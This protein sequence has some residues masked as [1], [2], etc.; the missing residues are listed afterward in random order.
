MKV[1]LLGDA[2]NYHHTLAQ[3][4]RKLG[5][6]VTVAS[7][8]SGWMQTGRDIDISRGSGRMAG[9][10][11]YAK[12]VGP[13]GPKLKGFDV[14]QL[15]S[16]NFV[17]LRPSRLAS[18]FKHLKKNNGAVYLTALGTDSLVVRD[19]LSD[20]PSLAYSEWHGTKGLRPWASTPE[21]H[22]DAWLAKELA[23]YT[24][25]VYEGAD[26]IVTALY[27]Y[28]KIARNNF[29][30]AR[31]AYGGI[32]IDLDAIPEGPERDFSQKIPL[33]IAAHKGRE[34]EKGSNVLLRLLQMVEA[35]SGRIELVRPKKNVP[36]NDFVEL[37]RGCGMV[38]DQLYSYTPATT[39][40]LA[41]A[42]GAIPLSGADEEFYKF[43]GEDT[44]R[45]IFNVDSDDNRQLFIRLME[46]LKK[47]DELARMS[48]EGREF[49]RRHNDATVVAHRFTD[50]WLSK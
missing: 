10:V 47:P 33:L 11:L 30:Q 3:G 20:K 12:L 39:A 24:D 46:L 16:P 19:C 25:A 15:A 28:H 13:F 4:L 22:K 41:M 40:L 7:D 14:V 8:G 23:D 29:P 5:H 1:L 45:P 49:V 48:A 26:G 2:S 38:S 44:L 50:F 21:A 32:P 18:V 31:I 43:I 35:H 6:D 37:I 27:E 42:M 36:F 9:A 17:T 34:A